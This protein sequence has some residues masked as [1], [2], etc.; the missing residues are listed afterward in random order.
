MN[1]QNKTHVV[2][3]LP[4]RPGFP[5]DPHWYTPEYVPYIANLLPKEEYETSGYFI[6]FSNIEEFIRDMEKIYAENRNIKILNFCDGGEWDGYLGISLLIEWEKHP[7]SKKIPLSGGD[8]AFIF[9]SDDKMKMNEWMRQAKLNALIQAVLPK[10]TSHSIDLKTFLAEAGLEDAWPLYCKLNIGAAAVGISHSSVCHNFCELEKQVKKMQTAFPLSDLL[11]Q[12][13]L[14]GKEYT[15]LIINDHI[16]MAVERKFQNPENIM[17]DDY[18]TGIRPI[19]EEIQYGP[20]P[21]Q[22]GTLALKAV[23]AIPGRHHYTRL[24]LRDDS[25]GNTYV[26]DINDR[27]GFGEPSTLKTMLDYYQLSEQ[28]LLLEIVQTTKACVN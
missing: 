12:P 16:Y 26:I 13:Y 19:E 21:D 10:E 11:I 28:T 20:V 5:F 24:D 7:I 18:L 25:C 4:F 23:Q 1:K 14:A 27:P 17:L 8:A 3:A 6:S 22:I 2:I 15:I 9:N